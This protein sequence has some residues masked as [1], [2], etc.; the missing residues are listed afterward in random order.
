ME[1]STDQDKFF[2]G[3]NKEELLQVC[4]MMDLYLNIGVFFEFLY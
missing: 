2:Y 4:K 3:E 1:Q